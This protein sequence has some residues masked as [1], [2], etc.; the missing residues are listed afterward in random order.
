[1]DLSLNNGILDYISYEELLIYFNSYSYN[2]L[3]FISIDNILCNI[4]IKLDEISI[5]SN[6]ES[7]DINMNEY[8]MNIFNEL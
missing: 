3:C 8:V 2:N 1:M 5:N 6:I 7:I 4:C